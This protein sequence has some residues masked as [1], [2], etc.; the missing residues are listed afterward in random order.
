MLSLVSIKWSSCTCMLR[1][2]T[3]CRKH[4]Y[5]RQP[6]SLQTG[7]LNLAR[8]RRTH[9][10]ATTQAADP[11]L[12]LPALVILFITWVELA[13]QPECSMQLPETAKY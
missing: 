13:S 12:A 10:T 2:P 6:V 9:A 4:R 7:H 5:F 1:R 3:Y 8:Q 11:W